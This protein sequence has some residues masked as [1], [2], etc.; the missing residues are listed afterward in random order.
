ME[1]FDHDA[2]VDKRPTMKTAGKDSRR[3]LPRALPGEKSTVIVS[4]EVLTS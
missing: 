1:S 2:H 4:G 3:M